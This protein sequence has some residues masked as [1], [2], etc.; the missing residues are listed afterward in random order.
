MGGPAGAGAV[1]GAHTSAAKFLGVANPSPSLLRC[2]TSTS[3]MTAC[4]MRAP[5]RLHANR[6]EL[7]GPLPPPLPTAGQAQAN[8]HAQILLEKRL[9]DSLQARRAW[10]LAQQPLLG[11]A[12]LCF[13]LM[14]GAAATPAAARPLCSRRA[15]GQAR[16][17][18]LRRRRCSWSRLPPPQLAQASSRRRAQ[19]QPRRSGGRPCPRCGS[20]C[21]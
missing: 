15:A 12:G 6:G 18:Q 1:A 3:M 2:S 11:A 8:A 19:W 21:R 5:L 9:S 7:W 4:A 17:L 10:R 13:R 20:W 14:P 16:H